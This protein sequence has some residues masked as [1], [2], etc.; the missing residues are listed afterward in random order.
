MRCL[1]R[2]REAS[3]PSKQ[4]EKRGRKRKKWQLCC[5]MQHVF[6]KG[7]V[8]YL[9]Y[10]RYHLY[11]ALG[12]STKSRRANWGVVFVSPQKENIVKT[13]TTNKKKRKVK[14]PMQPIVLSS[15]I[16]CLDIFEL[17]ATLALLAGTYQVDTKEPRLIPAA[18]ICISL[19]LC[20][21]NGVRQS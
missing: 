14:R 12:V 16:A 21:F 18:A 6:I 5:Y 1:L 15:F 4:K 11:C 7:L 3:S 17:T 20:W 13:E 10:T 8:R 2:C 9:T 19:Q